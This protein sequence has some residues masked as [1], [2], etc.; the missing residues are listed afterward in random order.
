MEQ[1]IATALVSQAQIENIWWVVTYVVLPAIGAGYLFTLGMGKWIV[2]RATTSTAR[3]WTAINDI[4]VN[5]LKHITRD[6][7]EIKRRLDRR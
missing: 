2:D 1:N 5:E 3:V 4:K 7:E 6:I